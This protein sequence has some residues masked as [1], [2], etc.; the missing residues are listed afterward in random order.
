MFVIYMHIYEHENDLQRGPLLVSP[1]MKP[2]SLL[3]A[4]ARRPCP[5]CAVCG[6]CAEMA[7]RRAAFDVRGPRR[8]WAQRA[9]RVGNY[10]T[11]SAGGGREEIVDSSTPASTHQTP[12]S[13]HQ[14]A[15][16]ISYTCRALKRTTTETSGRDASTAHH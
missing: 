12:G 7:G 4:A 1:Q 15:C 13:K 10:P 3:C 9:S 11:V 8:S 5:E 6:C 2:L 14:I 16:F